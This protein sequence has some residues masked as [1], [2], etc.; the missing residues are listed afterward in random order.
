MADNEREDISQLHNKLKLEDIQK[1]FD[2]NME[3]E[4]ADLEGRKKSN[5]EKIYERF[6]E[7]LKEYS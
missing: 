4:L 2:L 7:K 5:R 1:T 6:R 3:N